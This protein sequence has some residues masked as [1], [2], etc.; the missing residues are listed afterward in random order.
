MYTQFSGFRKEY[1][2]DPLREEEMMQ[3][4]I[5]QFNRWMTDAVE[6]GIPEPNAMVLAT[7]TPEGKPSART[8]L[9]K[10]VNEDGFVFFTNYESRK[11]RELTANPFAA[12][13]F[14]W[15]EIERQ[16]RI[17]GQVEKISPEESDAYF[18]SRPRASKLGTWASAQS[19]LLNDRNELDER[20][21]QFA[22]KFQGKPI[23]RPQN[24]GGF[25]IRPILVEFWQGRPNRLHDRIA[26]FKADREWIMRRLAP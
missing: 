15:H 7:A 8:V 22:K 20:F 9:L 1:K 25:L 23:P 6:S 13:V 10:E 14:D 26:Y 11:G 19:N 5:L 18:D 21:L 17:E 2:A 4:P 3:D 16:I 24:W 12:V